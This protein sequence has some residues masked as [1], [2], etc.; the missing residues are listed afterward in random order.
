MD[1]AYDLLD[2][3][4][5]RLLVLDC[6]ASAF[7]LV[8]LDRLLWANS[9]LPRPA[10][11]LVLDRT[12][13]ADLAVALFQMGVDEYVSVLDHGARLAAVIAQ[14]LGVRREQEADRIPV[15]QVWP[16]P[17][18]APLPAPSQPAAVAT[19]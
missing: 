2:C 6:R 1:E 11:V 8:E 17:A 13:D 12:Y 16:R 4:G 3:A 9:T 15:A 18:A 7:T 10:S 14:L 5:G 19:A